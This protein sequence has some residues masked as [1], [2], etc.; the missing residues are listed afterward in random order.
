MADIIL[1]MVRENPTWGYTRIKG[2]LANLGHQ[3]G[4]ST[5][6]RLLLENGLEP[7]PRRTTWATFLRSHWQQS[8]F[9]S[10][11]FP[12]G[13]S[14]AGSASSHEPPARQKKTGL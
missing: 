10:P 12:K 5:V 3:V 11:L 13:S 1:R 6:R 9:P 2:A 7:S 4:R 8:C 14:A